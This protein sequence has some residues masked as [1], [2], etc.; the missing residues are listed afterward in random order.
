MRHFTMMDV[1]GQQ[2]GNVFPLTA[3]TAPAPTAAGSAWANV[4]GQVATGALDYFKTRETRKLEQTYL[5]QQQTP[6]SSLLAPGQAIQS[7][8]GNPW[9][10]IALAG[11]ALLLMSRK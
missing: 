1:H 2:L 11:G 3:P 6:P 8:G 9:P 10:L 7:S 5:Q 4:F